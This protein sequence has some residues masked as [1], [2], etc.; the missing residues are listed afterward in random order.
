MRLFAA[1]ELP[2]P[3]SSHLAG[4][5]APHL[6]EAGRALIPLENWHI[7]LAFY[8]E[9]PDAAAQLLAGALAEAVAGLAAMTVHLSGSGW[10]RGTTAWIGLGGQVKE[11]TRLM[12]AL[13][14]LGPEPRPDN[15]TH[16]PHLTIAR[17]SRR[18]RRDRGRDQVLEE[19]MTAMSI[20]RGPEWSIGEVV[21]MRSDL[22]Q[23]RG[24]RS[25]YTPLGRAQLGVLPKPTGA[26]GELA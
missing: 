11:L 23:G 24:G 7:T 16:R 15:P 18:S 25:L 1:A 21:L 8:G 12:A 9:A 6:P 3:V 13:T 26:S 14:R 17:R 20:Y 19:V 22:G 10:F 2:E 5:L 4:A